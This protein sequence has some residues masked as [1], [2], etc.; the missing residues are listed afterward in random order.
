MATLTCSYS[1]VLFIQDSDDVFYRFYNFNRR[2]I[3]QTNCKILFYFNPK[4][5]PNHSPKKNVILIVLF[6]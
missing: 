6:M 2:N 1:F 3:G 5:N 4:L